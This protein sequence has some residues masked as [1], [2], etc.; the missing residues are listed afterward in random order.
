MIRR[1]P[2]STRT[3]TLFPYTTLFR[4]A[5]LHL[6]MRVLLRVHED[7]AVLVEQ[8]FVAL[9]E[10]FQVLPVLEVEPGAPIGEGV[11]VHACCG[12][13]RRPHARAGFAVPCAAGLG[14]V[15]AGRAPQ[16]ELLLVRA[17]VVAA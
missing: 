9:D 1:P 16:F 4:S 12:V 7:D 8:P 3:D 5:F 6:Y 13:Q 17:A 14:D 11:G 2:R 15:L 10:D